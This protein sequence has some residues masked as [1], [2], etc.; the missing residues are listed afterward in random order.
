MIVLFYTLIIYFFNKNNDSMIDLIDSKVVIN[1]HNFIVNCNNIYD[2]CLLCFIK[3]SNIYL[4]NIEFTQ[5]F[6]SILV[7]N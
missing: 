6:G 4:N 2:L 3:A 7:N 5:T 1:Q